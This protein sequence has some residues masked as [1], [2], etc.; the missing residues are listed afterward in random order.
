MSTKVIVHI[1]ADFPDPMA[2]AKTNS[3]ANLIKFT[4]G[5][6]HVVYSL[7]RV[8]LLSG[9]V[10]VDFGPDRKAIA[11]G[12]PPKGLFLATYL[13]HVSGWILKDIQSRGITVDAIHL[14]KF[15]VEGLVGLKIAQSLK[16]PVY[17]QHLGRYGSYRHKISSRLESDLE[18]NSRPG[19]AHHPPYPLG[20]KTL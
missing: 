13:D 14:H 11:Y 8:S 1:S 15:S 2:P 17:R 16:M 4:E 18:I 12:A 7:N 9:I 3:V 6:R 10:A 5:Y 19:G 20:R